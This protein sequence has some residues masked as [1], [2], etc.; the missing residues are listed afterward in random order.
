MWVITLHS[1]TWAVADTDELA[2]L[3]TATTPADD[4]VALPLAPQDSRSHAAGSAAGTAIPL[5]QA[6]SQAV[7]LLQQQQQQQ[8]V[9]WPGDVQLHV[10]WDLDNLQPMEWLELPALIG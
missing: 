3:K 1:Y 10:F 9:P 6:A 5:Q 4:L 7:S 8:A 2:G